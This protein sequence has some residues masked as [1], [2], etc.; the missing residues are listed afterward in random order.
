[1]KSSRIITC[2]LIVVI[3]SLM[4][5]SCLKFGE[6]TELSGKEVDGAIIAK[7][8][9]ITGVKFPLGTEGKNYFYL[10]DSIDPALMLKVTIPKNKKDEFLKNKIFIE[11]D[12]SELYNH[13]GMEKSWWDLGSLKN[14]VHTIY[15]F[16]NGAFIKCF[17]GEQSGELIIYLYWMTV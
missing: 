14:P 3:L 2:P 4:L 5:A 10:G 11:G 1:M 17:V 12:D 9:K 7:V 8:L 6:N 16:P 13:L 15:E